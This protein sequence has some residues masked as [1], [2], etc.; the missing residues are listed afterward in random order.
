MTDR[1]PSPLDAWSQLR[2]T[3]GGKRGGVEERRD[4]DAPRRDELLFVLQPH[5][6]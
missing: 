4:I 6:I 1:V 5:K 3:N 2:G